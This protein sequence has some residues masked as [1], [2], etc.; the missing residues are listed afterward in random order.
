MLA[1]TNKKL[2]VALGAWPSAAPGA[3]KNDRN[4]FPE[5]RTGVLELTQAYEKQYEL[6]T[7]PK[8]M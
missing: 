7:R 4:S 1:K 6:L 3:S 5:P 2:Q 8:V